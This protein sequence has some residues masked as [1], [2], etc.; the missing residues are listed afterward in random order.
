MKA[1]RNLVCL[2]LMVVVASGAA[3]ADEKKAKGKGKAGKGPT[4]TQRFVAKMELSDEQKEKVAAID[5]QFA[6]RFTAMMK[7]RDSI[8]TEDQLKA[9]K[10]AMAQARKDGLKG[11]DARKA[12]DAAVE[13]TDE[14]KAQQK[15]LGKSEQELNK[16]IIA[17]LKEVL[18]A[19]QQEKLPK[20]RGGADGE[21]KKKKKD[22]A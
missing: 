6:E 11:P 15:A 14:Q 4:A 2:T 5:K 21:K 19:E 8:L 16:E 12:I 1:F 9:R 17:S 20:S 18:T 10:E 3:M 22:A 13:L 7:K